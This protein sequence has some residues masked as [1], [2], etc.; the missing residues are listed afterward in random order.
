[1]SH[2][3]YR[4]PPAFCIKAKIASWGGGGGGG[5]VFAGHYGITKLNFNSTV[6]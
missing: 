3:T 1:M 6:C 4:S 2:P 5:S